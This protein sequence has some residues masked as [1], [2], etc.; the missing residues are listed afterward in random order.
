VL[1]ADAA[2][3]ALLFAASAWVAVLL[4]FALAPPIRP[5]EV[6]PVGELNWR[7]IADYSHARARKQAAYRIS[8]FMLYSILGPLGSI[9]ARTG[10]GLRMDQKA[11]RFV[12]RHPAVLGLLTAATA[13]ASAALVLALP[14]PALLVI[15]AALLRVSA[16]AVNILI[17]AWLS[18]SAPPDAE[19]DE[20]DDE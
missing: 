10:R 6:S 3:F 4:S 11:E 8:K 1:G 19:L 2:T 18:S 13:G 14:K 16:A 17:W 20:F 7:E 5:K 12:P 9:A 15:A